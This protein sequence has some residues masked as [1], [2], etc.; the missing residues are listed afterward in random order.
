MEE[1]SLYLAPLKLVTTLTAHDHKIVPTIR[2]RIC[3]LLTRNI[4]LGLNSWEL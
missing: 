3:M 2:Q 4:N 1:N